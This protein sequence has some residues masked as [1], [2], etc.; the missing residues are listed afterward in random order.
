MKNLII[1]KLTVNTSDIIAD[2]LS[3]LPGNKINIVNWPDEYPSKPEVSF[4]I[5]HDGQNIFLQYK[6]H[7]EEILG[8]VTEDNGEVWTDSCV[9]F[10][11]AFDDQSYYNIESTCVGRVLLG[12]RE[13][14]GQTEHASSDIMESI[15]RCPSLGFANRQK[16]QGDFHWTLTLMIP[17]TAFWKSN[18]ETFEGLHVRGNFYKCGDNLS[19]PHFV[20]W[21]NINTPDPSF[22]QPAF[23]GELIFE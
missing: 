13:T 16:E 6:V 22:H 14:E 17:R 19:T 4:S 7:E 3:A 2:K 21:T 10:F 12:Y 8:L 11:I 23:F 5:A 20:S 9:E 15:Q 18:I 1:P